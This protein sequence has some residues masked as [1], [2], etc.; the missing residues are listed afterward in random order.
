MERNKDNT[1]NTFSPTP[2]LSMLNIAPFLTLLHSRF[3]IMQCRGDKEEWLRTVCNPSS[4]H[5]VLVLF[6]LL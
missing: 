6:P 2:L 5:S 3:H 4:F 1:K